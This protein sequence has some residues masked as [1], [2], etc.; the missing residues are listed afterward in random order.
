LTVSTQ[1]TQGPLSLNKRPGRWFGSG[2]APYGLALIP[3][4]LLL[5]GFGARRRRFLRA[6]R[7]LALAALCLTGFG[8]SAC[9]GGAAIAG[10]PA[11][12]DTI[13]VVATGS[14]GSF[15]G[16]TQQFTVTLN[17]Q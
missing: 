7:L 12:A 17:V 14:G 4:L 5:S 10:T 9:G 15:A 11:G 16:V 8:L 13:T 6:A 2:G 3:G 1:Q